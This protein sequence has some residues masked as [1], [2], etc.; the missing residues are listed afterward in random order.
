MHRIGHWL[1]G[2]LWWRAKVQAVRRNKRNR[3]YKPYEPVK[4]DM[5]QISDPFG[6]APFEVRRKVLNEVGAKARALFNTEYQQIATWFNR[7]DPLYLLS[8][9]A[10]YF[11]TTPEGID[12]EAIDGKLDFASFHLELLQAFALMNSR[13]CIATPLGAQAEELRKYLYEMGEHLSLAELDFPEDL[14]EAEVNKR[15]V[16]SEMRSQTFAIRHC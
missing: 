3:K 9:C 15:K 13:N 16:I 5:F 7:Y 10:F 4:L 11:L 6:Q 8:Y 12:K 14:S 2:T 1:K